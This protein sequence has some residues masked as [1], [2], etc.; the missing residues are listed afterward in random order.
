MKYACGLYL[1][2]AQIIFYS[3]PL[4]KQNGV[5]IYDVTLLHAKLFNTQD[6]SAMNI[7]G[8]TILFRQLKNSE[9]KIQIL[10]LQRDV[11]SNPLKF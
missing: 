1:S 6:N 8:N 4:W 5:L 10:Y 9:N 3:Q 7:L 11:Y 2:L